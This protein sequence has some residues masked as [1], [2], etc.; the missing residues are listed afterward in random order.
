MHTA[1]LPSR[2]V[3]ICSASGL[4]LHGTYW[5]QSTARGVVVVAH[6]FGEHGGCYAHVAAALGSR[7]GVAVLAPDLRGHGRS[8]GRRGVV[9][10]Y[11]DLTDDLLGALDWAGQQCPGRPR[12]IL[13][14]SNGGQIALRATLRRTDGWGPDG[15]ILSN[16]LLRLSFPVPRH[17]VV[18]GRLLLCLAPGLTLPAPIEPDKLSRDPAMVPFYIADPLRHGRM[19]APLYFGMIEGGARLLERLGAITTRVLMIV[20]GNDPV[21]DPGTCRL[22]F[23]RLG[24][25]DKTLLLYPHMLHEPL[26]ELGRDGVIADLVAWLDRELSSLDTR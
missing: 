3:E 15:L 21:V 13:G 12:F 8:P 6:G 20:G 2:P 5:P 11:D 19:S 10:T 14:H 17:K 7:A 22:A 23:D 26:N 9:R 25:T 4:R 24:S 1:E 18:L 16:P